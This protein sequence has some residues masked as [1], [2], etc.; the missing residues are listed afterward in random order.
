MPR[1]K[2][3]PTA[4]H[5]RT[6][7]ARAARPAPGPEPAW[8]WKDERWRK[9]VNKVRAGRALLPKPWKGGARV[10]VALGFDSDHESWVL[11]DGGDSPAGLASG[12]YGPRAAMPRIL[13]LLERHAIPATFF[14]PAVIAKLH[15]EEQRAVV[16]GGHEIG[17]HGWIHELNSALS[18][19]VE[20]NL[21]FRSREVLADVCGVMPTGLRTP[22]WDF[23]QHTLSIIREMKLLYDSSLMADDSPYELLEDGEP[24]GI[25][26]LPVEWIRDD[27]PYFGMDRRAGLRPHT[28][29]D[30]V[31]AI[32]K[33]EFD[34]ALKEGGLFVLTMH[35]HVIG[36][37]SRMAMLETLVR[38][39]R[40]HH[41]IWFATHHD[42][43]AYA[44]DHA[45]AAR[46][47][48]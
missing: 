26:E 14:V 12:Q 31:L 41:G 35:P 3:P 22:S 13:G 36:H 7:S 16:C 21:L 24:T 39:M 4:S 30:E 5:R 1:R 20:R 23:S 27:Y 33:A 29:P 9:I 18:P 28:P 48:P 19:E 32:W 8:A 15:P 11:R 46:S 44:R 10:A 17:I 42:I 43:A 40:S 34:G 45:I 2:E 37:H 6:V 47:I 25:V 38:Y